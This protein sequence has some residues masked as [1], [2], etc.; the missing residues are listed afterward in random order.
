MLEH[1]QGGF[2]HTINSEEGVWQDDPADHG[3]RDIAFVPL[4]AGKPVGHGDV[5]FQNGVEAVDAFAGAAVHLVGHGTG[6]GLARGEAFAGQFVSGHQTHRFGKAGGAAGEIAERTD[7]AGVEAAGI[8][9]SDRS[10]SG[11][12]A[13]VVGDFVFEGGHFGEVAAEQIDLIQLGAGGAFEPADRV[14]VQQLLQT[15]EAADQF[16]GKHSETFAQGGGLGSDV[17]GAGGQ[18]DVLVFPGAVRE[19]VQGGDAF[20]KDD[21]EGPED[22]ELLDILR[23]VTAGHAFVDVFVAGQF[24]EFVDPRFDIV[25]GS[26]LAAHDGGDVD[27]VA[28]ALVISDGVGRDVE[29]EFALRLHHRDP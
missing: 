18:D 11:W 24:A 16:L 5:T 25:P 27:A 8:H 13:E 28:D 1:G 12:Q 14:A 3:A 19:G 2:Q 29:A 10:E 4:V 9:L 7:D 23:E 22:L 17:M 6:T 21:V 20:D 15:G 26:P